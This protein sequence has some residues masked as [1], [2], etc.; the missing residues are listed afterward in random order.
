MVD[1]FARIGDTY[2]GT[3]QRWTFGGDDFCFGLRLTARRHNRLGCG[4][5]RGRC[6]HCGLPDCD[7]GGIS[8]GGVTDWFEPRANHET[9]SLYGHHQ[10]GG[11]IVNR[12]RAI[13]QWA[14]PN[15][16]LICAIPTQSGSPWRAK[17]DEAGRQ[18]RSPAIQ[19]RCTHR[20]EASIHHHAR[21]YWHSFSAKP[22]RTGQVPVHLH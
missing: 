2:D 18:I 6:C 3:T 21:N 12:W 22:L 17:P 20:I 9:G 15:R 13:D 7:R 19:S 11:S 5:I 10:P 8:A 16:R 1:C 14:M 4:Q